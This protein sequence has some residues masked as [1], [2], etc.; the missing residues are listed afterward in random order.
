MNTFTLNFLYVLVSLPVTTYCN[1][2]LII[3]HC[4]CFR[5]LAICYAIVH[6]LIIVIIYS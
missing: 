2:Y 3:S 1:S 4:G 5:F 6:K